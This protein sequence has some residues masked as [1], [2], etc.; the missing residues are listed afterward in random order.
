M[1]SR[2]RGSGLSG[3]NTALG[4]NSAVDPQLKSVMGTLEAR[5]RQLDEFLFAYRGQSAWITKVHAQFQVRPC[6]AS[7]P[8]LLPLGL[9]GCA[10]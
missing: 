6:A 3:P 9:C 4:S 7:G 10:F 8:R 1:S 5:R 2:E